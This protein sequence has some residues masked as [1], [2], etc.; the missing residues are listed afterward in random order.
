V[1]LYSPLGSL[2]ARLS[3]WHDAAVAHERRLR[4][5]TTSDRCDEDCPHAEARS[6]W[7]EAV[8]AFGSRA[9]ELTFLRSR[10]TGQSGFSR[11][12]QGRGSAKTG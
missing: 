7:S 9:H 11:V 4:S 5:G 10:A 2:S 1:N 8:A 6:L 3:A 12:M